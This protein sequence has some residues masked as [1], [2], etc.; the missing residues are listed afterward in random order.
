MRFRSP[1]IQILMGADARRD[2]IGEEEVLEDCPIHLKGLVLV[3]KWTLRRLRTWMTA[4]GESNSA[5]PQRRAP[6]SST[7]LTGRSLGAETTAAQRRSKCPASETVST[8]AKILNF[9]RAQGLI[10]MSSPKLIMI[11]FKNTKRT[12]NMNFTKSIN[13]SHGSSN[14]TIKAKFIT[15]KLLK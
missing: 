15:G 4:R 9:T 7:G 8:R 12:R 11:M 3:Q 2:M 5:A 1:P 13:R 10:G 6:P 14:A